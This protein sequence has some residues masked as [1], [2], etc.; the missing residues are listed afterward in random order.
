MV[1]AMWPKY[2]ENENSRLKLFKYAKNFKRRGVFGVSHFENGIRSQKIT[3]VE[4]TW[5][6]N[7][8]NQYLKCSNKNYC[9][10]VFSR[11]FKV[12]DFVIMTSDYGKSKWWTLYGHKILEIWIFLQNYSNALKINIATFSVWIFWVQKNTFVCSHLSCLF[13]ALKLVRRLFRGY[14]LIVLKFNFEN[15]A[16][17]V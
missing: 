15:N 13:V 10:G 7:A 6:F 14:F 5:P 17:L 16:N 11:I 9:R 3:M 2:P 4:S 1:D 8:K 12:I